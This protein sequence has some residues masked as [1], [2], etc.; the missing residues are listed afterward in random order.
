MIWTTLQLFSLVF[1]ERIKPARNSGKTIMRGP[2]CEQAC[3]HLSKTR[4]IEERGDVDV[5]R[6]RHIDRRGRRKY[7]VGNRPG[8][9]SPTF[10]TKWAEG[11]G[12][13]RGGVNPSLLGDW[14]EGFLLIRSSEPKPL[15]ASTHRGSADFEDHITMFLGSHQPLKR[16]YVAAR[17]TLFSAAVWAA[18]SI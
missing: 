5:A 9:G 3:F 17:D 16:S 1:K 6:S 4:I 18:S 14:L 15:R 7:R 2:A 11:P 8:G 12:R 13:G 10:A